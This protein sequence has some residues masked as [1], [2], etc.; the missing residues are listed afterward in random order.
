MTGPRLV[1][2]GLGAAG[3]LALAACSGRGSPT[4]GID[5]T[6]SAPATGG[7]VL[8]AFKVLADKAQNGTYRVD[9]KVTGPNGE[10]QETGTFYRKSPKFRLDRSLA[11]GSRSFITI[12][13][14]E[15]IECERVE[16]GEW[17]CMARGAEDPTDGS[18]L[19]LRSPEGFEIRE[20][21]ARVVA[22]VETSCFLAVPRAEVRP[23][24]PEEFEMCLNQEG[25]LLF[26]RIRFRAP[27][28]QSETPGPLMETVREATSYSAQVEDEDFEP[29]VEPARP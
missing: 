21:E 15:L 27:V 1:L 13:R 20:G 24:F 3:L 29:P 28:G 11:D 23:P 18:P 26:Q 7:E 12:W 10:Q 5:V 4:Q 17:E 25:A 19:V 14:D 22:G 9:F 6:G 16:D 8:P 2:T